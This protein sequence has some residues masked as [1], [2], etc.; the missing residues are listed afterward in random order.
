MPDIRLR[1]VEDRDLADFFEFQRDPEA[2]RMA[3]FTAPDPDDRAAFDAFWNRIRSDPDIVIRTIEVDGRVVGSVLVYVENGVPEASY[4]IDRAWWG[5]GIATR[6]LAEFLAIATER[7]IRA[8]AAKDN[9]G[10]IRVLQKNGFRIIGDDRG[11]AEARGQEI[12]EYIFELDSG[13]SDAAG[14]S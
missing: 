5:R 11:Y 8:R 2:S 6:A 13:R 10:S 14:N 9:A 7:P 4:W 1:P 12:G 3:A